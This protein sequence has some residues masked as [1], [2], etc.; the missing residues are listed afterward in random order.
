MQVKLSLRAPLP[1]LDAAARVLKPALVSTATSAPAAWEEEEE[2]EQE[3]QEEEKKQ[4]K[5]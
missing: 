1:D 5:T 3:E 2:E 4:S